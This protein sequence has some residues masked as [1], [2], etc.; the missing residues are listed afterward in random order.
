MR[1]AAIFTRA[2]VLAG[3]AA[4]AFGS[5]GEAGE[6]FP[7]LASGWNRIALGGETTCA[8]ETPYAFW[9]RPGGS[10]RLLIYFQPGGG[11]WDAQTCAPG[12]TFFDDVVND[13]DDPAGLSGILDLRHPE[14]PFRDHTI[15]FHPN[16][17]GW[18]GYFALAE[19]PSAIDD[20]EEW[21]RR[22]LRLCLWRQ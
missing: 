11:C 4:A 9:V 14:N 13:Q 6:A 20:L 12:S 8:R 19:T 2:A 3:A 21:V 22:R 7:G 16:L 5:V 18:I 10:D 17:R 1:V 15:V